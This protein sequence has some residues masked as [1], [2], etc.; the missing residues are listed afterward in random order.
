M[1]G[2]FSLIAQYPLQSKLLPSPHPLIREKVLD[3]LS[4]SRT[5]KRGED[6]FRSPDMSHDLSI[7]TTVTTTTLSCTIYC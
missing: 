1:L 6:S 3:A 7:T 2:N 4:T 5:T